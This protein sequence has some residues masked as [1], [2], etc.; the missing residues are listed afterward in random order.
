MAIVGLDRITSET[1]REGLHMALRSYGGQPSL[2]PYWNLDFGAS[3]CNF[4][5]DQLIR[6]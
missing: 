5:Q 4:E 2:S 3:M 6:S 1:L